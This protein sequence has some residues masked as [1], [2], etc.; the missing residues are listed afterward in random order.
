MACAIG[1]VLVEAGA[2]VIHVVRSEKRAKA[3][4]KLFP[5]SP[6]FCCDAE[7]EENIIRVRDEIAEQIGAPLLALFIP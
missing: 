4:Q 6:V 2:E 3:C 7:E 1:K 5:A